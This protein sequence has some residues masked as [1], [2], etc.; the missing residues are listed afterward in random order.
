MR[1]TFNRIYIF[2]NPIVILKILKCEN[3]LWS[4]YYHY[5]NFRIKNVDKLFIEVI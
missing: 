1:I 4:F 2:I 5:H 3:K